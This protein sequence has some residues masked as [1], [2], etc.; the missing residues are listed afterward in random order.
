MLDVPSHLRLWA[1]KYACGGTVAT[2]LSESGL[3]SGHF[4]SHTTI[5]GENYGSIYFGVSTEMPT[6]AVCLEIK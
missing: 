4:I 2:S 6:N 1:S 5:Q 3:N